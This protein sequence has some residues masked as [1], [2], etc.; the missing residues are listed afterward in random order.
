MDILQALITIR[1]KRQAM[2]L[3]DFIG[4][5]AK[6]FAELMKLFHAG[7]YRL[8]Q[9]A[10]G[11]IGYCVERRPELIRPHLPKLLDCL[12]RDDLHDAVRRNI[13]RLLQYVEIPRRLAGKIYAHCIDFIDDAGEP[14]AVRAFALTVAARIAKSEPDLMKELRLIV[15]KHLPH[16]TIAF[17]KRAREIL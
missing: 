3:V 7:E 14:V 4:D 8:T 16:T 12:K 13:L 9:C 1:S 10:A 15:R 17:H 6:R 2:A 5:D 11:I